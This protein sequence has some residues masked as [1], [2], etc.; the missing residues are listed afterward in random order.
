MEGSILQHSFLTIS[1]RNTDPGKGYS[2]VDRVGIATITAKPTT[3]DDRALRDLLRS[4]RDKSH[5]V[6]IEFPKI[7]PATFVPI[8]ENLQKMQRLSLLRFEEYIIPKPCD[9]PSHLRVYQ[10]IAS[11]LYARSIGFGFPLDPIL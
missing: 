9:R 4:N 6:L 8:L 7:I 5:G 3:Q 2:L 1:L 11:P 10:S